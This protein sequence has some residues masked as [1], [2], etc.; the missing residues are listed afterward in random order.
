M[1]E[2]YNIEEAAMACANNKEVTF[3][4]TSENKY[5]IYKFSYYQI[6]HK[7]RKEF[8][9]ISY[10]KEKDLLYY[11]LRFCSTISFGKYTLTYDYKE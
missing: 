6:K 5:D 1:K 7:S 11:F 4:I 2:I 3:V 10:Q 8:K 9:H